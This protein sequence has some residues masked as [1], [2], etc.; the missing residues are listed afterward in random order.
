MDFFSEL[1]PIARYFIVGMIIFHAVAILA[2]A[3]LVLRE[4]STKAP[5]KLVIRKEE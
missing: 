3:V 4:V 5:Q 2:Y 1:P